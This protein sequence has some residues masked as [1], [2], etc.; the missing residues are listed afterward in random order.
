MNRGEPFHQL[1]L[2]SKY[3]EWHLKVSTN[4]LG[5]ERILDLAPPV[6]IGQGCLGMLKGKSESVNDLS[7]IRPELRKMSVL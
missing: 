7:A 1:V 5:R 6:S 2:S 3:R 4:Q